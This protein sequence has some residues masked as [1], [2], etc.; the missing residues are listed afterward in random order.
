MP[1]STPVDLSSLREL[2]KGWDSYD[3]N[4]ITERALRTAGALCFV[5]CANGGIQVELHA[6]G[7]DVEIEIGPDGRVRTIF[8]G[9]SACCGDAAEVAG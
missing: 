9:P 8:T 1:E 3:G 7:V 2:G 4:P 5:P 6:G